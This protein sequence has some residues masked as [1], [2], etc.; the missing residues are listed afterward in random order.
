MALGFFFFFCIKTSFFFFFYFYFTGC[1]VANGFGKRPY[2]LVTT[3]VI[4]DL[5]VFLKC[6]FENLILS[7][8]EP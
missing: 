8:N 2:I 6:L 7:T 3:A 5:F 4:Q 1:C